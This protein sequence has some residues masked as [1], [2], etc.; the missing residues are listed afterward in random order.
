[1]ALGLFH[2][3]FWYLFQFLRN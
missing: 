2:R 1:M 3:L